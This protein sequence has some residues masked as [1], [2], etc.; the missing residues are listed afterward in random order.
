[1]FGI[2]SE[3][4]VLIRCPRLITEVRAAGLML[5]T[6]GAVNNQAEA[7]RIQKRFGV[8]AVIVDH[9]THIAKSLRD[10]SAASTDSASV[11]GGSVG[12]RA[13]TP[14]AGVDA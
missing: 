14:V 11:G 3:A 2:V 10:S 9:V 6:Y 4:S 13:A 8:A 1:M 12:S 7:V 5:C